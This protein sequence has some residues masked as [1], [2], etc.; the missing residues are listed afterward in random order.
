MNV[1]LE[2]PEK[3]LDAKSND[4][5]TRESFLCEE[6]WTKFDHTGKCYKLITSRNFWT[7]ALSAC[8]SLVSDPSS[9]LASIPDQTTSDF[10]ITLSPS[11]SVW[12]GGFRNS[13]GQWVW[14]DG[15]LINYTNWGAGQPN[16]CCGGL[17]DYVVF[18]PFSQGKWNDLKESRRKMAVCQYDRPSPTPVQ[19]NWGSWSAWSVCSKPIKYLSIFAESESCGSRG[20]SRECDNP[21]PA[22]GGQECQGPRTETEVCKSNHCLGNILSRMFI[23]LC[24]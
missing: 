18:Y 13:D 9:T 11:S 17:Q 6:G 2:S 15:S 22:H 4:A 12:V 10:L 23:I 5:T 24:H 1:I 20:R 19:G 21:A 16:N 3:H 14:S 8:K 7:N